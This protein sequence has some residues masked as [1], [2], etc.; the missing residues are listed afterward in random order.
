MR[1][2][3][4][5]ELLEASKSLRRIDTIKPKGPQTRHLAAINSVAFPGFDKKGP[6][7][8]VLGGEIAVTACGKVI[9][10]YWTADQSSYN[11]TDGTVYSS[12]CRRCLP[13]DF[14][15]IAKALGSVEQGKGETA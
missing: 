6:F 11:Y 4:S 10:R 7:N 9:K 5:S 1:R 3:T 8:G 12:P 14:A 13:D 15:A 2:L